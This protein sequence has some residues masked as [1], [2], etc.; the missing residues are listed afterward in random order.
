[1]PILSSGEI[2]LSD[3]VAEDRGKIARVGLD[4]RLIDL[5]ADANAGHGVFNT[6][7][8]RLDGSQLSDELKNAALRFYGT[9]G[10]AFVSAL[11]KNFTES[12]KY[13]TDQVTMVTNAL[14]ESKGGGQ[15]TR[16]AQRFAVA[17]IAGEMARAALNLPWREGEVIAATT[18]LYGEWL[19]ARGGQGPAEFLRAIEAI[20][21]ALD[22]HGTSRFEDR[23]IS[24][25]GS[26]FAVRERL[27]WRTYVKEQ[28]CWCF[29][30]DGWREIMK[31]ISDPRSIARQLAAK[32]LLSSGKDSETTV[33][34]KIDGHTHR[35]YAVLVEALE[36]LVDDV[37]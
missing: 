12:T 16:V 9:A 10:P 5:L 1:V 37:H 23:R 27:G 35:V 13:A 21:N 7:H 29:S 34:V 22:R 31:G 28:E 17:G 36:R 6:L 30:T 15:E 11:A 33:V 18:Q 19:D 3:K 20:K 25:T 32:G 26:V 4:V 8:E 2:G 24:T 14:T